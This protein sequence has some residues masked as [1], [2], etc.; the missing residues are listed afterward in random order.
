MGTRI[1]LVDE[2]STGGDLHRLVQSLGHDGVLAASGTDAVSKLQSEEFDLCLADVRLPA[3]EAHAL[4]EAARHRRPPVPVVAL[5]ADSTVQ[6]AVAALRAGAVDFLSKP[7]HPEQFAETVRRALGTLTGSNDGRRAADGASLVGEHPAVRLMLERIDQVAGTDA[8]ILI[9]GEAGTGKQMIARLVHAASPRRAGPFVAV[10]LAELPEP[11]AEA[12]LFGKMGTLGGSPNPPA[13]DSAGA[14]PAASTRQPGRILQA[15]HGT[16]FL[17]EVASLP[18]PLQERL[19]RVL[20]ER[21]IAATDGPSVPVDLRVI[22]ASSR[23]LEQ[24]VRDGALREDLYYRLDVIPIEVPALRERKEDIPLLAE[25][26]RREA[27]A[28][29]GLEVPPFSP[30]VVTRLSSYDWPGNI[31]QLEATIERL[32]HLAGDRA[33]TLMDLPTTLRA[34]I[35]DLGVGTLD[36]PPYGVDLRLLLTRLEDRLIGQALERTGG[37]KNRAAELLGMNRTTLVEKL[38]RRNVA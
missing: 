5:T 10:N 31:R 23:N 21:A 36:L 30:E 32:V 8:N 12:E 13:T 38:R 25:Y 2:P 15:Q 16:L 11:L 37:N 28:R 19:L 22:A 1:L 26:F 35:F 18:R 29:A 17:D 34:D 3:A 27:N 14:S 33:V 4:L 7:F 20:R 24:L 9:R 6:N